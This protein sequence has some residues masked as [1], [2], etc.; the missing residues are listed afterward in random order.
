MLDERIRKY[1]NL[2][3]VL[4]VVFLLYTILVRFIDVKPIGPA[5]SKVGWAKLNGA[6]HKAVGFNMAWYQITK[7]LGYVIILIALGTIAY[8]I[9]QFVTRRRLKRVDTRL[10]V[11]GFMYV[12][13]G[14]IYV[15]FEIVV[16]NRR[17]VIINDKL[18]ASYPSTHTLLAIVIVLCIMLWLKDRIESDLIRYIFFAAC[19]LLVATVVIGRIISGVHWFTDI[20][21]A[22]IL[23]AALV[24]LYA[25]TID[26]MR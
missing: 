1:V 15:F 3:N 25:R 11:L 17:P 20:I 6:I 21:G 22:L 13:T 23:G 18:A 2:T 14:I 10:I 4:F 24:S 16:I 8:G 12:L 9:F 7:Y 5:D 19:I 26:G